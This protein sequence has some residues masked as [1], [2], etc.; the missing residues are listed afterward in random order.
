MS[1]RRCGSKKTAVV[2]LHHATNA[3][4]TSGIHAQRPYLAVH[5]PPAEQGSAEDRDSGNLLGQVLL[6]FVV[7]LTMGF[8]PRPRESRFQIPSSPLIKVPI[9]NYPEFPSQPQACRRLA[10]T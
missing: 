3:G 9:P 4:H 8:Q 10:G 1:H 2:V 5:L 7:Y 6:A